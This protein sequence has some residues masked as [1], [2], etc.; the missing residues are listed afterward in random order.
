MSRRPRRGADNYLIKPVAIKELTARLRAM[1]RRV[2]GSQQTAPAVLVFGDLEI[3]QGGGEVRVRG[4]PVA[5]THTE[6]LLLR[7]LANHSGQ[8]VSRQQLLQRAWEYDFGDERLVDV[9]VGRL[10]QK[11]E[12]DSRAPRHL[13]TVRG[14]G[15]KL[16]R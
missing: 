7:E 13:V 12:E 15:Y 16:Q 8:V 9:H 14:M 10:R 2:R 5:L 6:F 3:V 4:E 11:I 1:R